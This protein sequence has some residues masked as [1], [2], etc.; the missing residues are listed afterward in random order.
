MEGVTWAGRLA[1]HSPR[2]RR[3]QCLHIRQ[4]RDWNDE[5]QIEFLTEA[6]NKVRNLFGLDRSN[7][8]ETRKLIHR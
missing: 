2:A 1:S 5:A 6:H 8:D 7:Q 4:R 3:G